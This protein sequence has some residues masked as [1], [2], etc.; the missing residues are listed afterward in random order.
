MVAPDSNYVLV[1][2]VDNYRS[3]LVGFND[4][5]A[6]VGDLSKDQACFVDKVALVADSVKAS[7]K[8]LEVI[9]SAVVNDL[10]D[11]ETDN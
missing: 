2:F 3:A 9:R 7:Q 8:K 1:S 5:V 10:V 11:A 4:I 6:S